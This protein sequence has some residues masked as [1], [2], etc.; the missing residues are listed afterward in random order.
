MYINQDFTHDRTKYLGGSDIGPILGLSKYRSAVDVWLEKTGQ[1]Q[2]EVDNLPIRFGTY[3]EEFVAREYC[4][5]TRFTV[6][7]PT[8]TIVHPQYPF[9]VAHI[10]RLVFTA[11]ATELGAPAHLLECKTA[12]PFGK[13]EWGK[14]VAMKCL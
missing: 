8:H 12:N 3:A 14:L 13:S 6:T 4:R 2:Y 7:P 11:A 9:L 1:V 10:D 5:Q